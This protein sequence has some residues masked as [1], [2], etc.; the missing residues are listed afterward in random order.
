MHK[1]SAVV[2]ISAPL[3]NSVKAI[4]RRFSK[5]DAVQHAVY[6][7]G[8]V[9]QTGYWDP[10]TRQWACNVEF[11]DQPGNVLLRHQIIPEAD[12]VSLPG[13]GLRKYGQGKLGSRGPLS[14]RY[15]ARKPVRETVA[16]G[17]T[18]VRTLS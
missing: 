8:H 11:E 7:K 13:E 15:G 16:N 9:W 4:A 1:T 5:G 17:R 14:S 18:L 10:L 6:G 12:L 3:T 2:A